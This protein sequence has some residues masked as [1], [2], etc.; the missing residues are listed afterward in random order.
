MPTMRVAEHSEL[1]RTL[2][3][4]ERT[5]HHFN[6]FARSLGRLDWANQPSPFRKYEGTQRVP[7]PLPETDP[8]GGYLQLYDREMSAPSVVRR[9]SLG[10]FLG[11]Q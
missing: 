10:A 7:L 6:R 4:H 1:E 5:K 3:Y 11:R 8:S 9:K 2:R